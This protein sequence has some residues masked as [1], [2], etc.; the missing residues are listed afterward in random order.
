MHC[1]VVEKKNAHFFV[2][3]LWYSYIINCVFTEFLTIME[4]ICKQF[5]TLL[6]FPY[7]R[8]RKTCRIVQR[9]KKIL[10]WLMGFPMILTTP[11][12]LCFTVLKTGFFQHSCDVAFPCFQDRCHTY[13]FIW[14]QFCWVCQC[15][16]LH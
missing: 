5:S 8:H 10:F 6:N 9:Q 16:I 3:A 2:F 11:G 12:F 1:Q 13:T 15:C 14:C 7:L 4:P